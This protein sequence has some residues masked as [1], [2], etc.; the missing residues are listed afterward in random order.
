MPH[1]PA[2]L[3]SFVRNHTRLLPVAGLAAIEGLR[4]HQADDVMSLMSLAGAE[5]GQSDPPL[6]FWAFA[7]AGGLGLCRYLIDHPEEVAG[8]RVVD[9]ASGSGLCAIVAMRL[10][11]ASVHAFDI[12]PL[13]EAAAGL[14]AAAN[15]VSVAFGLRDPL[16]AEPPDRQE[17]DVIMAG[18]IFYEETM[19]ARMIDWLRRAAE[20]GTRVL[21]GDPGRRYLP[22]GLERLATYQ[23]TT[24]RELEDGEAKRSAIFT[25]AAG[26]RM[27]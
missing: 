7:W 10:G 26:H 25:V 11:A 24:T 4:L 18:D 1:S 17:A 12:D 21:I 2:R 13:A 15:G 5:L 23:V 9:V 20:R 22:P 14:N 16:A 27:A 3:R 6:P 8:C 19:A